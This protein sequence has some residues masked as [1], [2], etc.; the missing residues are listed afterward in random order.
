MP[1][2]LIAICRSVS[3][4]RGLENYWASVAPTFAQSGA[5]PLIV[6]TPFE[7]LEGAGP[8]EGVAMIEFPSMEAATHWYHSDAYQQVKQHRMGAAVYDLLLASGGV[9]APNDRMPQTKD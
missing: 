1:V 2:Y 9:V 8:I 7:L 4:R 3:N 5:K 6:Y